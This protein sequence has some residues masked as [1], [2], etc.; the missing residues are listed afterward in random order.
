MTNH[1]ADFQAFYKEKQD[2]YKEE[3]DEKLMQKA[4][5]REV[6][7]ND[8][9]ELAFTY[10]IQENSANILKK[11]KERIKS[12]EFT[13]NLKKYT[14]ENPIDIILMIDCLELLFRSFLY[15]I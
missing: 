12:L 6:L 9:K 14:K 2:F 8:I 11:T 7:K 13:I 10:R 15:F 3:K 5:N 4:K 1:I